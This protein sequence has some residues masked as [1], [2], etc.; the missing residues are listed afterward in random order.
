MEVERGSLEER[1]LKVLLHEYPIK[2]SELAG[3]LKISIRSL[4]RKLLSMQNCGILLIEQIGD[5]A[6]IRLL[7]TDFHFVEMSKKQRKAFKRKT[8]RGEK[9]REEVEI[10]YG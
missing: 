5:D 6:F 7:R 1:I 9:K 8:E 10:G 2:I 4:R 3:E